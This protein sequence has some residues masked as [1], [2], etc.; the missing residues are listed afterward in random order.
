MIRAIRAVSS[1]RGRD[2]RDY[3]LCAFGGNGPLFAAAMA[4]AL[5]MRRVVIPPMPGLF[6]AFGLL[7]SPLERRLARGD[8]RPL[9]VADP[10]ELTEGYVALEVEAAALLASDGVPPERATLARAAD[11]RYQG[12]S[13]E[14]TV[15]VPPGRL[16]AAALAEVA[17]AFGR[18]HARTYGHRA[19]AEEPVELVSLR[20]VARARDGRPRL[21]D[22]LHRDEPAP[23]AGSRQVYF[24]REMG[25][26]TTP[27]IARAD[28]P[29]V[30]LPGPLIVEEYDAT[31][32][33]PPG[34]TIRLDSLGVLHLDLG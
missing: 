30:P 5:E 18:E 27:I 16:D 10:A 9:A 22:Q 34:A 7:A 13:F 11:L 24:G 12:Q 23:A 19:G 1:E 33:V 3:A 25:W 14:L 29:T 8:P 17:E 2:P 28:V 26:L 4:R 21:P 32:V 6:S 20:V 15:P 31:A